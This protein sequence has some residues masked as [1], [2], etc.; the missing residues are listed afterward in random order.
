VPA[1]ELTCATPGPSGHP[2]RP[3]V[4]RAS[5]RQFRRAHQGTFAQHAQAAQEFF[6]ATLRELDFVTRSF[7]KL[8]NRECSVEQAKQIIDALF[9]EPKR[10]RN[11][12]GNPGL[13]RNWE[14]RRDEVRAA[15]QAISALRENGKGMELKGSRGTFWCLLNAVLE[16]VDHHSKVS[17]SRLS[18]ALLGDGMELKVKAFDMIQNMVQKEAA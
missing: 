15:R 9:P 1:I 3:E 11:S 2:Y 16:Y 10:P 13:L 14:R 12:E 6:A 8:S 18:Y 4:L 7:T 17:G 5:G